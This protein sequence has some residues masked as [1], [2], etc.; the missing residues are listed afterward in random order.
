MPYSRR[1]RPNLIPAPAKISALPRGRPRHPGGAPWGRAGRAVIATP[2]D[3]PGRLGV[4][5]A[6]GGGAGSTG[7]RI[8]R[9]VQAA[10]RTPRVKYKVTH[11]MRWAPVC[12]VLRHYIGSP[13]PRNDQAFPGRQYRCAGLL[14]HFSLAPRTRSPRPPHQRTTD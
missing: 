1:R 13:N 7:A 14:T 12:C 8:S 2:A 6:E 10:P 4:A 5:P 9:R 3:A 11:H